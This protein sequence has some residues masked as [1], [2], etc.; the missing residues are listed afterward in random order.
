MS[1]TE[2]T[3]TVRVPLDIVEHWTD[4]EV[5]EELNEW[6][7][8]HVF[9]ILEMYYMSALFV[10]SLITVTV[11][12]SRRPHH[13]TTEEDSERRSETTQQRQVKNNERKGSSGTLQP[14]TARPL[15]T[16]SEINTC[17]SLITRQQNHTLQLE[18]DEL[19]LII[20][21]PSESHRFVLV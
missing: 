20:N 18:G 3:S 9:I 13:R 21:E 16:R 1:I 6:R 7:R 17:S 4:P 15:R 12:A 19:P 10:W 2:P 5:S 14:V 8:L 11:T